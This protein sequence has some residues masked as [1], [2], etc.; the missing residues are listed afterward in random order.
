MGK[1]TAKGFTLVELLVVIAIICLL[2][3]LLLPVITRMRS[4]AKRAVCISNLRQIGTATGAYA[5]DNDRRFPGVY[6]WQA[7]PNRSYPQWYS[8]DDLSALYPDYTD[9]LKV[10]VCPN[11]RNRVN[12]EDDLTHSAMNINLPGISYEYWNY[13][14]LRWGETGTT[15]N[16][17]PPVLTDFDSSGVNYEVD[18]NDNHAD[19]NGG[20]QLYA[21]GSALWVDAD[22]WRDTL[23]HPL[24][25]PPYNTG[26]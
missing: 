13:P 11:T 16:P 2:I 4:W 17:A 20:C 23:Y 22:D 19:L 8:N 26:R 3:A 9:E 6:W 18:A 24:R 25:T 7:G 12:C 21:D 1:P 14:I 15:D 5:F 10:F